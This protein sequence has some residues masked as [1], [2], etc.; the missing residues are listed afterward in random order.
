MLRWHASVTTRI[1]P[2]LCSTGEGPVAASARMG[3]MSA[4]QQTERERRRRRVALVVVGA[5]IASFA[6]PALA[7]LVL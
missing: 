6:I 3:V 7:I 2:W 5:M 4:P 1:V